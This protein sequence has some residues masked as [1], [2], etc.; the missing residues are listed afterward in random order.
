MEAVG[1]LTKISKDFF[2][3]G[4]GGSPRFSRGGGL[5]WGGPDEAPGS[6]RGCWAPGLRVL[7]PRPAGC[8]SPP[9]PGLP[10]GDADAQLLSL[11]QR[12]RTLGARRRGAAPCFSRSVSQAGRPCQLLSSLLPPAGGA[13]GTLRARAWGDGVP[14]PRR[15][16]CSPTSPGV[17][18]PRA[19]RLHVRRQGDNSRPPS[20][21]AGRVP[22]AQPQPGHRGRAACPTRQSAGGRRPAAAQDCWSCP[23]PAPERQPVCSARWW[24][25]RKPST[26]AHAQ[27]RGALLAPGAR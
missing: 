6:G 5:S 4:G 24:Q 21:S 9:L 27:L 10:P 22:T 11:L 15:P 20:V 16:G 2:S 3:L 19:V 23:V 25:G 1:F 26:S 17:R 12:S 14:P 8:C 7:A 18:S 13:H